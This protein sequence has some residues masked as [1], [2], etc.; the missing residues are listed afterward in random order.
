[1]LE[2][3]KG[4]RMRGKT[5]TLTCQNQSNKVPDHQVMDIATLTDAVT[6]GSRGRSLGLSSVPFERS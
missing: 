2:Q 6:N 3:V 4:Y 5:R 1:M